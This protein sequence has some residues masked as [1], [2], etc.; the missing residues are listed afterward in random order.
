MSLQPGPGQVFLAPH[1]RDRRAGSLFLP[2][3]AQDDA[4]TG[5][6]TAVG[7][8]APYRRERDGRLTILSETD[9]RPMH[10][11]WMPVAVGDA[12]AYAPERAQ[13]VPFGYGA[14]APTHIVLHV[15]DLLATCAPAEI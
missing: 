13:I 11:R 10:G 8:G 5:I 2:T 7:A 14:D 9:R 6:V 1:G 15:R 12:V 4:C 3:I